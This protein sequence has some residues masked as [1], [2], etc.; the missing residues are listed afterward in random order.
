[1]KLTEYCV[2]CDVDGTIAHEAK[3]DNGEA[4]RGWYDYDL[5]HTDVFD[6]VVFNMVH[7]IHT[8][9]NAHIVF[10]TA[11]VA[12]SYDVTLQWLSSKMQT[13]GLEHNVHYTLLMRDNDDVRCDTVFKRD[14]ITN[15]ILKCFSG[16]VCAFEDR[17]LVVDTYNDMGIKT[18]AVADQRRKF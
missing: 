18:I 10:L 16:I 4:V 11:R 2:L 17:P 12:E 8:K 14:V 7:A 3:D 13:Y 9:H 5:V 1:M 15:N 6:D